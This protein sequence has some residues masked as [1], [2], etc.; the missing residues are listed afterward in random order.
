MR[1]I[2][3]K[4]FHFQTYLSFIV[5]TQ[6]HSHIFAQFIG[7][8]GKKRSFQLGF[9]RKIPSSNHRAEEKLDR[10]SFNLVC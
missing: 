4:L 8:L 1:D 7:Y 9:P 2:R 6:T 10:S 3:L 5:A